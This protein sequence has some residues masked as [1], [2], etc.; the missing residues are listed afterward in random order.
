MANNE[1]FRV[2]FTGGGSG[3][4]IYPLIAVAEALQRRLAAA[5]RAGGDDLSRTEG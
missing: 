4:H 5:E 3:G 1:K 2:V